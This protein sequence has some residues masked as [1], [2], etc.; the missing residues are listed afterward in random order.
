MPKN[1]ATKLVD[2]IFQNLKNKKM[3]DIINCI[4]FKTLM[5]DYYKLAQEISRIANN[6]FVDFLTNCFATLPMC[7]TIEVGFDSLG[8]LI[9]F[10]QG[11]SFY[12]KDFHE[13]D[14]TET[15]TNFVENLA[16]A[17]VVIDFETTT[18]KRSDF[19]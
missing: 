18:Y 7:E 3:I 13:I 17:N 11:V 2:N 9:D 16:F 15:I 19:L 1:L 6:N 10:N 5:S 8:E 12:D 14:A 4:A